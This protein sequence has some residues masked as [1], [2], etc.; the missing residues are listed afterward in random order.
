[1]VDAGAGRDVV[2]G[3]ATPGPRS[4][5]T[6]KQPGRQALARERDNDTIFGAGDA[7]YLLGG[8]GRDDIAGDNGDDYVSGGRHND[9][10][11]GDIAWN[12][13]IL[14]KSGLKPWES[15]PKSPD[16]PNLGVGTG[17]DLIAGGAG[18]DRILPRPRQE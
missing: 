4:G 3:D 6:M 14:D 7:D 5:N 12:I 8:A 17:D 10:L 16:E 11:W 18:D 13:D 9:R 2:D 1:V 15:V